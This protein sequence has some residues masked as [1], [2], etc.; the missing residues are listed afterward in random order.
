MRIR[1]TTPNVMKALRKRDPG[2][3]KPYNFALSPILLNSV[4][5]CTLVAP[6]SK[7]PEEWLTRDYV[8]VY[9]GDDVKLYGDYRGT[10]LVPQTL[11]GVLWRHYLHPEDKSL[12]PDGLRCGPY[13]SGLLLRRPIQAIT[14]F[15][16]IGKE[17]ERTAQEGEDI[18]CETPEGSVYSPQ[19]CLLKS[20]NA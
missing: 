16:T 20:S 1:V 13:T 8:E 2:A 11:A 9:S 4:P 19:P 5:D 10:K 14:P 7:H 17:V 18:E 6:F 12:A 3:A 15:R